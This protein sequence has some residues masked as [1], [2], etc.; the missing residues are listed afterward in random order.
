MFVMVMVEDFGMWIE[1]V[2]CLWFVECVVVVECYGID[3]VV[4]WQIVVEYVIG[5]KFLWLW[6]LF[7]LLCVL[8]LYGFLKYEMQCVI[9]IVVDVEMLYFVF[10]LY[11]D[12]I[13]GDFFCCCCLNLIGM[14]VQ[15]YGVD[16]FEFVLY[17]V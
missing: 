14:F 2:L 3:F 5:G 9:G 6:L 8:F 12:V 17:W 4:F 11:D 1:E 7:D 10:F 15:W 13:D 16:F